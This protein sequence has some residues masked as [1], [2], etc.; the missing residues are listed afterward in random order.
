MKTVAEIIMTQAIS[1]EIILIGSFSG[2]SC[3]VPQ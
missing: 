3:G 1:V 2:G